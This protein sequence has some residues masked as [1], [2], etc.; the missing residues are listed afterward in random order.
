MLFRSI[1]DWDGDGQFDILSGRSDGAVVWF[2]NV[3][4][5]GAPQ[6]EPAAE[7]IEAGR[8]N[9]DESAQ[10]GQRSQVAVGDHN[11]DGL[12]DILVGDFNYV[13]TEVESL[14]EEQQN[15][16]GETQKKVAELRRKM[17]TL[18]QQIKSEEDQQ[19]RQGGEGE[20]AET[21]EELE[22]ARNELET[23]STQ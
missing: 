15:Q 19:T 21:S 1:A 18:Q 20:Q 13:R 2:R 23:V 17:T 22:S 16:I 7:L 4:T 11:G 6:F 5:K 8:K 10:V 12:L 3:G 9:A 14:P